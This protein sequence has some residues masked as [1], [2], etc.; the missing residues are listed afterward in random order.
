MA[1]RTQELRILCSTAEAHDSLREAMARSQLELEA[2]KCDEA[3][4]EA[5][6]AGRFADMMLRESKGE[7]LYSDDFDSESEE[8]EIEEDIA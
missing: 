6:W 2:L 4:Q 3:L 1:P 8:D 5:A 7:E